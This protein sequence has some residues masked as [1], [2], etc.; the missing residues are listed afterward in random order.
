MVKLPKCSVLHT[1]EVPIPNCKDAP[2]H[3]KRTYRLSL[4]NNLC[5]GQGDANR[6]LLQHITRKVEEVSD[7]KFFEGHYNNVGTIPMVFALHG[8]GTDYRPMAGYT[9]TADDYNFVLILPEGINQSFNAGDCCGDAHDIGIHDVDF[10]HHIQQ[11]LSEEFDFVKPEYSYGIGWDNGALLLTDA[12]IEYPHLFKAIVPIAG[13]STRKWVPSSVGTGVGIMMHHSLDDLIMRPSGCCDDPEMPVCEGDHKTSNCDSVLESFDLWA[14]TVNL[15]TSDVSEIVPQRM[16]TLLVGGGDEA[17]YSIEQQDGVTSMAFVSVSTEQ[18]Q[19]PSTVLSFSEI[20]LSVTYER[21]RVV[22]LTASSSNCISNSTLCL[23]K[24][25]GHF[26]GF[27]S[28]PFMGEQVMEFLARDACGTNKGSL[29]MLKKSAGSSDRVL[30]ECTGNEYSGMFC[31]DKQAIQGPGHVGDSQLT[32]SSVFGLSLAKMP[33]SPLGAIGVVLMVTV[34]VLF[35]VRKYRMKKASD[36]PSSMSDDMGSIYLPK[37]LSPYQDQFYQVRTNF[38]TGNRMRGWRLWNTAELPSFPRRLS[39]DHLSDCDDKSHMSQGSG[40][41]LS[42][43]PD[44]SH[45]SDR[46]IKSLDDK[47]VQLLHFYR[48]RSS[49]TDSIMSMELNQEDKASLD[50]DLELLQSYRRRQQKKQQS[51]GDDNSCSSSVHSNKS[52]NA[53]DDFL[54]SD[55]FS[56]NKSISDKQENF[57]DNNKVDDDKVDDDKVEGSDRAGAEGG[58]TGID[59]TDYIKSNLWDETIN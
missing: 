55:L 57:D 30:C 49:G 45:L 50:L 34:T 29:K 19:E 16:T 8:F 11:V 17:F 2:E 13:Y 31:L 7:D 27:V 1:R 58:E 26:D 15:C 25:M 14:R 59:A 33:L 21:D 18:D 53:L 10:L 51:N 12:S 28:T 42:E 38:E 41:D 23:Y 44:A 52:T 54:F 39:E 40:L 22:C 56:G 32:G 48:K 47:D 5:E 35:T 9:E 46:S 4:P 37:R 20:P 36:L 43:K 24:E 6:R 3:C